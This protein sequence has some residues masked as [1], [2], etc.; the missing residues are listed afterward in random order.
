MMWGF[1]QNAMVAIPMALCVMAVCKFG[2]LRPTMCHALWLVVLVKLMVPPVVEWP[3]AL[4]MPEAE[5]QQSAA[6][7]VS[8]ES[9]G[10]LK[11]VGPYSGA[12]A[13]SSTPIEPSATPVAA[14]P[15]LIQTLHARVAVVSPLTV[16]IA[17]WLFGA[18]VMAIVQCVRLSRFRRFTR[19]AA[20][21]VPAW[22]TQETAAMAQRFG[23]RTPSLRI[24]DGLSGPLMWSC[25]RPRLFMP[26]ALLDTLNRDSWRGVLAHELAHIKRRDHWVAWIEL[27]GACLWWWN[28]LYWYVRNRVRE[29]A[30]FACDAWVVWAMPEQRKSYAETLVAVS[31][32]KAL[33]ATPLSALAMS[34]GARLAFEQR[35]TQIFNPQQ[36]RRL[37]VGLVVVVLSVGLAALPGW[38]LQEETPGNDAYAPPAKSTPPEPVPAPDTYETNDA[39]VFNQSE[40]TDDDLLV[41]SVDRNVEFELDVVGHEATKVQRALRSPISISFEGKHLDDIAEFISEYV[42]VPVV[43]DFRVVQPPGASAETAGGYVTDGI[44][45]FINLSNISLERALS[46]LVVPLNL[47]YQAYGGWILISTR[48]NIDT[49]AEDQWRP[50]Q[51]ANL[52]A[53]S[54]LLKAAKSPI[55]ISFKGEHLSEITEFMSEYL[56]VNIVLD[57]RVIAAPTA[58]MADD[59]ETKQNQSKIVDQEFYQAQKAIDEAGGQVEKRQQAPYE[60]LLKES[61][62]L[63]QEIAELKAAPKKVLA[64][65]SWVTDGIVHHI[66]VG[67]ISLEEALKA[68][69]WPLNLTFSIEH[70][71][72]W[73]STP[74][75]MPFAKAEASTAAVELGMEQFDMVTTTGLNRRSSRGAGRTQRTRDEDD[76][77]GR[78]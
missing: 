46:A 41:E 26:A 3:W 59:Y 70:E 38:S 17:L 25:G 44:V 39:I 34:S 23:I 12:T 52:H 9:L 75:Y 37:S 13:T 60:S 32:L 58:R 20:Q 71:F 28:P 67:D 31:E 27:A 73:I 47:S 14:Q 16:L 5:V 68:L 8:L 15:N 66:S 21:A 54:S 69:L 56:E 61:A 7:A 42:D 49:L 22:L 63:T 64:L 57:Q 45:H 35:L 4:P 29:N 51:A 53:E 50:T 72:I 62:A 6:P 43:V 74:E 30:E 33:R 65:D 10:T 36:P 2:K 55:S 48:E 19:G 77:R 76:G 18:G 24:V 11:L 40:P 1:L 78:R